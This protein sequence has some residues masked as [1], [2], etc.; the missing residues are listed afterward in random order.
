MTLEALFSGVMGTGAF[1][2]ALMGVAGA[3]IFGG[4]AIV[5]RLPRRSSELSRYFFAKGPIR[6]R[7]HQL[8]AFLWLLT[9]ALSVI[10]YLAL[11]AFI[12]AEWGGLIEEWLRAL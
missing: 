12:R 7:H 5:G 11:M 4:A 2:G 3:R 6:A 9:C 10:P 8:F 1:L